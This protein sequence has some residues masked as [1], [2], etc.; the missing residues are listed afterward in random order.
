MLNKLLV[1]VV[2]VAFLCTSAIGYAQ[3][4]PNAGV[5]LS[6]W[7][8]KYPSDKVNGV[9]FFNIPAVA[10]GL[11]KIMPESDYKMAVSSF[12]VSIPI[13]DDNGVLEADVCMPH[14]CEDE[15]AHIYFDQ[16]TGATYASIV[17]NGIGPNYDLQS[18]RI[19][20]DADYKKLPDKS[21]EN[22]FVPG[23]PQ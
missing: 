2:S 4:T 10:A 13:T 1:S 22:M 6:A 23:L 9:N 18:T 15:S 16:A 8:G 5:D 7:V 11:H 20:S 14:D 19:Y 3:Q 17:L 12:T 21:L